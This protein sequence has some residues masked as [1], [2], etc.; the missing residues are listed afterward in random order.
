[1]NITL[2]KSSDKLVAA[3]LSVNASVDEMRGFG[4]DE[5][6]AMRNA[7]ETGRVDWQ[8]DE[9]P[10]TWLDWSLITQEAK[11]AGI[12]TFRTTAH[13]VLILDHN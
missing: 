7:I 9:A 12:L 4:P 5:V 2:G 6:A 11:R 10:A 3:L 13:G 8:W 1:M